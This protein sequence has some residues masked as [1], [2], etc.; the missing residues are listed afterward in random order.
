MIYVTNAFSLQMLNGV[1]EATISVKK[2]SADQAYIKLQGGFVSAVGHEAT[3]NF[4]SELFGIDIPFN[5]FTLKLSDND[6]VIVAR[7]TKGRLNGEL[8]DFKPDDFQFYEVKI[9]E[10]RI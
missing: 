2:L 6:T 4:L 7:Y 3:A 8:V 1:Y 5:R 9:L 10:R